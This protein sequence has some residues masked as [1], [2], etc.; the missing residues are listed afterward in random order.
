MLSIDVRTFAFRWMGL[1]SPKQADS[2]TAGH[3]QSEEG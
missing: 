1:I 3:W 2:Q